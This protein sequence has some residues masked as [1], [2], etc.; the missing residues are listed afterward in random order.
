MKFRVPHEAEQPLLIELMERAWPEA[1][2]TDCAGAIGDGKVRVEGRIVKN[3]QR[4]VDADELVEASGLQTDEVFGLPE[5]RELARGDGFVVVDKAVGMVGA[6]TNDPMSPVAF[7]ADVL[8]MDRDEFAPA[9]TMPTN[10][11]GPWLCAESEERAGELGR[12]VQ[13]GDLSTVW[14]AITPQFGLPTGEL[15]HEGLRVRYAAIRINGGLNELQL[16]PSYDTPT[17]PTQ[18]VEQLLE[19][20][21]IK[22]APVIG[23]RERGGY[24][25]PGGLRLRLMSLYDDDGLA[26]GW[27]P[28]NDWWPTESV[29][30]R[31]EHPDEPDKKPTAIRGFVVSN[32]T[33][34]V[35][36][37]GHPWVLPDRDTSNTT[38]Y[39]VGELVKL[40]SPDGSPGPFALVDGFDDVAARVWSSDPDAVTDFDEEVGM[41][42]DEAIGR[43][44]LQYRELTRTDLFRI[45]HGEA[46][47]LPG[48]YV[49]RVGPVYRATLVGAA[50]WPLREHVYR[51]IEDLEP[52]AMI[53]EVAHMTDVRQ[54]GELPGARVV[55]HGAHYVSPGERVIALEDGLRFWCEP[56]EGID[57]GF[58]ADQR[59]NRRRAVELAKAG[60]GRWLNLFCHTGAYTV[61]LVAAGA[62][63][64]S[65]DISK[66]YLTWLDQNLALNGLDSSRNT[67]LAEDARV[68]VANDETMYDGIIVD[69]PTAARSEAGFWSVRKD[70]EKLLADCFRRLAPGGVMLVCRNGRKRTPTLE[71]MVESAADTARVKLSGIEQAPPAPDY[72][73]LAGFPE[74][75]SFE[76]VWVTRNG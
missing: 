1:S 49:D 10:A 50:A 65:V 60:A 64:V 35:V 72:P 3:P 48:I 51:S 52:D 39:E 15:S 25:V 12:A 63:V 30:A 34:E 45:V 61:A 31:V 13:F 53:L 26:E 24:M 28:P 58:F 19:L 11:G 41:R 66:R 40:K 74:G 59:D 16:M 68:A 42:V 7:L 29:V 54:Q 38:D 62:E 5:A 57:T 47:G 9:W 76:A 14:V 32:K 18:L 21:A 75:D 70:Y 46:D 36:R 69:P 22:G 4:R 6:R 56:W 17:D 23:D 27:V 55:A 73:R 44:G 2:H 67:N 8:G 33:L 71:S 37:A 20:L 43:R